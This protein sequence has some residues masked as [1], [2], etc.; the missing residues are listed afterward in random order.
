[1][2]CSEKKTLGLFS[3]LLF[4]SLLLNGQHI[5]HR[6]IAYEN[7]FNSLNI[8][9][10]N[11]GFMWSWSNETIYRLD[12]NQA[13]QIGTTLQYPI[14]SG[15]RHINFFKDV[16]GLIW[17]VYCDRSKVDDVIGYDMVNLDIIDP[18]QKKIIPIEQYFGN[19]LP[20]APDEV[21]YIT[22]GGGQSLWIST[23]NGALYG[24]DGQFFQQFTI[25]HQL[26]AQAGPSENGSFWLVGA[27][28]LLHTSSEG[29]ILERCSVKTWPQIFLWDY[30]NQ[31]IWYCN[32]LLDTPQIFRQGFNGEVTN[33]NLPGVDTAEVDFKVFQGPKECLWIVGREKFTLWHPENNQILAEIGP[34]LYGYKGGGGQVFQIYRDRTGG[35]WVVSNRWISLLQVRENKFQNYFEE[36]GISMR[37]MIPINDSIIWCNS[38]TGILQ[39]NRFSGQSGKL[40]TTSLYEKGRRILS[41]K[42]LGLGIA[43][44]ADNVLYLGVEG[45]SLFWYD[46]NR[47]EWH[48]KEIPPG[49]SFRAPIIPYIDCDQKLWIGTSKGLVYLENKTQSIV[50]FT[51]YKSA[52][53][54]QDRAIQGITET[55]E[56]LWLAT[57]HGVFLLNRN[58][59]TVEKYDFFPFNNFTHI[60]ID[61]LDNFWM[62]TRGGGLIKWDRRHNLIIQLKTENGL[63]NNDAHATIEDDYGYLWVPTN[64]GLNRI[65]K[66]TLEIQ[67]FYKKDGLPDSEF[68][69][70]SY[71]QDSLG[72]IYLGTVNGLTSFYPEQFLETRFPDFPLVLRALKV[73]KDGIWEEVSIPDDPDKPLVLTPKNNTFSLRFSLLEYN[74]GRH[75]YAYQLLNYDHEWQYTDE[76][77]LTYH[78]LPAGKYK[79]LVKGRGEKG[80]WSDMVSL[81]VV[82]PSP[83]F[84]QTWFLLLCIT[85]LALVIWTIFKI[86]VISLQKRADKLKQIVKERTADLEASNQTKDKLFAIMGHELR[87]GISSFNRLSENIAYLIKKGD[88]HQIK[89]FSDA[90]EQTSFHLGNLLEDLL[91]WGMVQSKQFPLKPQFLRILQVIQETWHIYGPMAEEKGIDL[92]YQCPDTLSLWGDRKSLMSIFRNLISNAI[93]FT[94]SG[95]RVSIDCTGTSD[96]VIVEIVDNGIGIPPGKLDQIF[97]LKYES[98]LGTN[99]ERGTGLGLNL[100]QELVHLNQGKIEV[101]STVNQGTTFK[102]IFP[103]GNPATFS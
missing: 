26:F 77:T 29:E 79:L 59:K 76:P 7:L 4:C 6:Q 34:E 88:Y 58:L 19:Q 89:V 46:L 100:C 13:E 14:T 61:S 22:Q 97:S 98:T 41:H 43:K 32:T 73:Y 50:P 36:G 3:I 48:T 82:V 60:H 86:R 33:Y 30:S 17:L 5:V 85:S 49:P 9:E 83:L 16:N 71:L 69:F 78:R 57:D 55:D 52:L 72:K 53:E 95:G 18:I 1:M 15:G 47:Q 24:Y 70:L 12:P 38:Y 21:F 31:S 92:S 66:E 8:I 75:S 10:D 54:L 37:G 96:S 99:G 103:K 68:N 27:N 65:N 93:K 84:F 74:S 64:H 63:S 102:L 2:S 101:F 28:E 51:E 91:E 62:A 67:S 23:K 94:P 35:F 80:R 90:M 11:Q 81:E 42:I 40:A 45:H 44:S 39:V 25:Q 20:F 87:G 56:G